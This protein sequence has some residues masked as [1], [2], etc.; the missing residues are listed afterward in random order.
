MG[1]IWFAFP[2]LSSFN[3]RMSRGGLLNRWENARK[4]NFDLIEVPANFAKKTEAD[5][6][7]LSEYGF[8]TKEA[9]SK[10]YPGH[11]II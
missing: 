8:L 9:I 3:S 11:N 10:L 6:L 4:Y 1:E 7:G 5:F 2:N